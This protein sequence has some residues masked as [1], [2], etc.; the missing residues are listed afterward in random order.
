MPVIDGDGGT[1]HRASRAAIE[2]DAQYTEMAHG[3]IGTMPAA[4]IALELAD[5]KI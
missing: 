1:C 4:G 2:R 5:R 3:S